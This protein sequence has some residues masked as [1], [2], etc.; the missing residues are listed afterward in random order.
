MSDSSPVRTRATLTFEDGRRQTASNLSELAGVLS[1]DVLG[2]LVLIVVTGEDREGLQYSL[3]GSPRTPGLR[4]NVTGTNESIV[5]GAASLAYRRMMAGYVDRFG[6]WRAPV[7][8]VSAIAP[9]FALSLVASR[10]LD[11]SFARIAVI[12]GA[13]VLTFAVF[14]GLADLIRVNR[15]F[16]L[17]REIP[18]QP[19]AWVVLKWMSLRERFKL[20]TVLGLLGAIAIAVVSNKISDLI[21]WP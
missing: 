10:N 12:A 3:V 9:M 19:A 20:R 21:H 4:L 5:L 13:G 8:M 15:S 7:W 17:V 11:S 6:G 2:Q 1:A 14:V 16:Q 18:H